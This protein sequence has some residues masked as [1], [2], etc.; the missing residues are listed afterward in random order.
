M[1]F[2]IAHVYGIGD[3]LCDGSLSDTGSRDAVNDLELDRYNILEAIRCN[4]LDRKRC[5]ILDLMGG[6]YYN[7]LEEQD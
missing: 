1:Q 4:V 7:C 3:A 5:N 6:S 2:C